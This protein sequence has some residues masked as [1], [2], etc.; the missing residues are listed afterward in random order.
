[1]DTKTSDMALFQFLAN[2][3]FILRPVFSAFLRRKKYGR[4]FFDRKRHL[5]P[6]MRR[7]GQ[8]HGGAAIV[9]PMLGR[10]LPGTTSQAPRRI[11]QDSIELPITSCLD[12]VL[13]GIAIYS[14]TPII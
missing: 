14:V 6:E 8:L 4:K 10:H 11:N 3:A 13:C 7:F 1:M 12:Q 5:G 2:K 9:V